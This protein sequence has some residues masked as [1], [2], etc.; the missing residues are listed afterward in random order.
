MPLLK[1]FAI[2]TNGAPV[3]VNNIN[4]SVALCKKDKN[5]FRS[6]CVCMYVC[7]VNVI[8]H[9]NIKTHF[10]MLNPLFVKLNVFVYYV[11]SYVQQ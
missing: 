10:Y 6:N 2:A 1:L 3:V 5:L 8:L 9:K 11:H 7:I 4:E